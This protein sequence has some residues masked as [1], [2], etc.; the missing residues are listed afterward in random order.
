M[1]QNAQQLILSL[2]QAI[3]FM[4]EKNKKISRNFLHAFDREI[5]AYYYHMVYLTFF[6]FYRIMNYNF[7]QK[8]TSENTY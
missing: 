8:V 1:E 3:V 7:N 2:N 5:D 4:K 6:H